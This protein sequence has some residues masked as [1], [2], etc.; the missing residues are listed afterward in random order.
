MTIPPYQFGPWQF[1]SQ[2]NTLLNTDQG[3][4]TSL[5]PKVGDLLSCLIDAD[6]NVV[7]R[8][9]L[10]NQLWNDRV[11]GEDTLART[12]SKL[13][14]ALGDDASAP[15][16]IRT[17]PKRG[18]QFCAPVSRPVSDV[19]LRKRIGFMVAAVLM[20]GIV[21]LLL[22]LD[23]SATDDSPIT[24]RLERADGLYM[25]FEEQS[26]EAALAIYESVLASQPNNTRAQAGVAN[27]MVQRVVRWPEQRFSESTS[28]PS[29]A[30]A[31]S[32]GQ[33]NTSEARMLLERARRIAEKAVRHTPNSTYALKSLGFVY[34]AEGNLDQAIEQYQKAIR[35]DPNEWRSL[36]NLGEIY[37]IRQDPKAALS[38]FILAY[39]AMQSQ[40]AVEPQHVGPWQPALGLVI[41]DLQLQTGDRAAAIAWY[42]NVLEITPFEPTASN[43]LVLQLKATGQTQ[44]AEEVCRSYA[45]KLDPL[46]ACT[47][48][49]HDVQ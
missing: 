49:T 1:D 36:I 47:E 31:L 11:V 8:A 40:F 10:Q 26:N 3:T 45:R 44:Q 32:S 20:L 14:A 19:S 39:D 22:T 4:L 18:Y 33:L 17:I 37:Q 12:V 5:E 43:Q 48:S 38:H 25:R 29:V 46:P 2:T 16:Y 30:K 9:Q 13:R 27:A 35:I 42:Q 34:S 24:A 21:S 28:S 23:R 41:A 15:N 6:G 7:D